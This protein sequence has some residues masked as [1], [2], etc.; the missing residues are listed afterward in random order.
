MTKNRT[1]WKDCRSRPGC[2]SR[3][4]R[5]SGSQHDL[6]GK[7][8]IVFSFVFG[9]FTVLFFVQRREP[10]DQGGD[11][12]IER[13]AAGDVHKEQILPMVAA[14]DIHVQLVQKDV[15]WGRND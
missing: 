4:S 14:K 15:A 6:F 1:G 9:K 10:S 3:G 8:A 5:I 12:A 2:S 13:L 7:L 11:G